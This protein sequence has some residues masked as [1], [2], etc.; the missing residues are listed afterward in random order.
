MWLRDEL[1]DGMTIAMSWGQAL[2]ALVQAAS[3]DSISSCEIVQLLG[4]VSARASFVTA[5]ELV[6][7][8]AGRLGAGYRY[9]HAPAAFE[10]RVARDAMMREPS[11]LEALEVARQADLALVG[12]G[13]VV[14]GSSAAI[15]GAVGGTDAERVAFEAAGPVG[16]LAGRY[17]TADGVAITGGID[18]HVLGL[19]L[20]DIAAIP[21]VVGVAAGPQKVAGLL[22]AL[23]GRLLDVL[24]TDADTAEAILSAR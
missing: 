13:S 15:L 12:V 19:S 24:I 8:F 11:I 21:R 20:A 22:G 18:D 16:D 2:Q 23:R 17:F 3:A 7:E 4:G 1:K 6:R 9:L 14:E 5:Q 10:T